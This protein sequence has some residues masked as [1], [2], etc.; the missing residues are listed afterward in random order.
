MYTLPPFGYK[1]ES[2]KHVSGFHVPV[3]L[4]SI[5]ISGFYFTPQYHVRGNK[6]YNALEKYCLLE[7]IKPSSYLIINGY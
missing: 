5:C 2:N 3:I 6:G 7:F 1:N 4:L